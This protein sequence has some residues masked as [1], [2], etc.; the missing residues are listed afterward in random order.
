MGSYAGQ[1]TPA[2][3]WRVAMYIMSAFK[4]DA[5][6]SSCCNLKPILNNK[7]RKNV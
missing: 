4:A 6:A 2:D 3:R 1:L 5:P 7:N